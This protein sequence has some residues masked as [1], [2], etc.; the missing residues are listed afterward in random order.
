MEEAKFYILCVFWREEGG[1]L[2]IFFC[3]MHESHISTQS[4]GTMCYYIVSRCWFSRDK[5]ERKLEKKEV[6]KG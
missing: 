5:C 3:T 2:L 1:D 4:T 6:K